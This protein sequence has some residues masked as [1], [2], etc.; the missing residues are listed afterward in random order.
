[1]M[2]TLCVTHIAQMFTVMQIKIKR[3]RFSLIG[4]IFLLLFVYFSQKLVT[5][6]FVK[7]MKL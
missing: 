2:F 1:M 6:A 3:F 4:T 7:K 5:I